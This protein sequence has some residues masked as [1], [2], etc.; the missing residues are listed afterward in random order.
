MNFA[1]L[2]ALL[3]GADR[4][5]AITVVDARSGRGVPLV[6]LRTVHGVR[7]VTDSNGVVAFHEPGLMHESVFFHVSGH[8]Y[9]YPKDGFGFRGT[10]LQIKPG[11]SATLKVNRLNV[12]ERLYRLTGA[13]VYR[14]SVLAG[15]R[16]PTK[17]PLLNGQVLGSDSVLNAV[18]RGKLY[19]FWGDTLRPG[20]PLGNFHVPGATSELPATVGFD[21]DTGV[22]LTYFLDDRGFAKPTAE[23]P[24]KGPTWLVALTTLPDGRRDRLFGAFVKIEPPL[25]V[26]AQYLAV[27]E[28]EKHRFEKIADVDM[29][30]PLFPTGHAFRHTDGGKEYVYFASPYPVVRVP[31]TAAAFRDPTTYEGYSCLTPGGRMADPR[32]DRAADGRPR[33][34]WKPNTSP[35][36]P[37]EQAT[38]LKHG[39]LTVGEG[40][41]HLRDRDTGK[42]VEAHRGSVGW[43]AHRKRWTMVATEIGGKPSH[44]G[45]VWY[46]EADEPTGPWRYAV[47]VATHDRMSFYNPTQHPEFAKAGG[48]VIYFEGTYTHDFSGNPDV[49]PRYE[50]NQVMYRLDLADPRAALPRP[51]S[52]TDFLALDREV[53]GAIRLPTTPPCFVLPD[54]KDAPAGTVAVY[55]FTSQGGEKRFAAAAIDGYERGAKPA[56]RGWRNE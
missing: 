29:T 10:N 1:F 26:Y 34:A 31:A 2:L 52:G 42:V 15:V 32:I 5:F 56:G 37:T 4:P 14:D 40:R 8:G 7:S 12:A 38:L 36:G 28:D 55:E 9:E 41:W 24:G 46:A 11:G 22:D 27:W 39:K 18:Y 16:V 53:P 21:P 20:Y 47:K 17:H 35:V 6:E 45:E 19:W 33:F 23:L 13:G 43:N 3:L 44:L 51:V 49:T 48:R 30:A 25:K 50:Y 54:G